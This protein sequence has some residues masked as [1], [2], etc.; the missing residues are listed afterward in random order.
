M[1]Q[2][3]SPSLPAAHA[4]PVQLYVSPSALNA[5]GDCSFASPCSLD[6]APGIVRTM[7][8]NMSS[9]IIVNLLGGTYVRTSTFTLG[10][11]DSGS[12]GYSVIYRNAPGETPILSGGKPI[13]GWTSDT[14]RPGVYYADVGTDD[15]R[16]LYVG[17]QR[18]IRARAPNVTNPNTGEPYYTAITA[19]PF[20]VAAIQIQS[21][22]SLN[23]VEVVKVDHFLHKRLRIDHVNYTGNQ[24]TITFRS[25]EATDTLNGVNG[26]FQSVQSFYFENALELLDANQEW[27]LDTSATPHRV[28]LKSAVNPNTLHILA[29][30][31]ETLVKLEGTAQNSVH[32]IELRGIQFA[33]TTWMKPDSTG[34]LVK[35]AALQLH[36]DNFS[37]IPASVMLANT[38]HIRLE[39]NTIRNTGAH[40]IYMEGVLNDN[41]VVGNMLTDLSAGGIYEQSYTS[42]NNTIS[43]NTIS[44]A[45]R[46][47]TDAVGIMATQ[48]E[49][50]SIAFN[51]ISQAPYSCISIGWTWDDSPTGTDNNTI[52]NNKIH[53]VMQLHDDGAG[54]YSLGA[55]QS[56]VFKGNY[57]YDIV[58]S[59][60]SGGMPISGIY[61]DEGSSY[62]TMDGNVLSNGRFR[63]RSANV[64]APVGCWPA[65]ALI[66]K[67]P[68]PE[69]TQCEA[70]GRFRDRTK[71]FVHTATD[72]ST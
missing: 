39:G 15:F 54:I 61:M 7:N 23:R 44:K 30:R 38:N 49:R 26:N 24:A 9:N 29:P 48:P 37:F 53:D 41:V 66:C 59:A 57:I 6:D 27:Y 51:E 32:H 42:V 40:G 71:R 28:Y 55:M 3:A 68:L 52:A 31:V 16:Q 4:V 33:Y 1:L 46:A 19:S 2:L 36:S 69:E 12:N 20:R 17:G 50:M 13:T 72:R 8:Q 64:K 56:T 43:S 58:P 25:P 45:G 47:Y 34:Y 22:A 62:K 60:I 18:A 70:S 5:A 63:I 65:G 67:C 14:T 35:Q 21:W 11:G 10:A